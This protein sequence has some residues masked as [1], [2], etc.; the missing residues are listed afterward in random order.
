MS[1]CTNGNSLAES[2]RNFGILLAMFVILGAVHL[3]ATETIPAQRSRGEILIHRRKTNGRKRRIKDEEASP[4]ETGSKVAPSLN[5]DGEKS[6]VGSQ[7][8]ANINTT[9]SETFTSVDAAVFHWS[10]LTYTIQIGKQNRQILHDVEGWVRP[11]SLTA[12]MA[13]HVIPSSSVSCTN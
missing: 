3:I 13:S 6:H 10:S 2:N 9:Q 11:G 7:G 8:K 1:N 12:L 4:A 5:Y